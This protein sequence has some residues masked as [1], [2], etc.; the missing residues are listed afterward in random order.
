MC[1]HVESRKLSERE[2]CKSDLKPEVI[3]ETLPAV[4]SAVRVQT[5]GVC[6]VMS[7]VEEIEMRR[8]L[9]QSKFCFNVVK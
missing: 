3:V 1:D 2:S 5:T 6:D 4:D 9:Y 8:R 7:Y